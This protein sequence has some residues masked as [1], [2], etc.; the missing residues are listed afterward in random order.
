MQVADLDSSLRISK[1]PIL[2]DMVPCPLPRKIRAA[3]SCESA[4][5]R[6]R[7]R[8]RVGY[9]S[10]DQGSSY[11]STVK[12][13]MEGATIQW[14]SVEAEATSGVESDSESATHCQA[15]RPLSRDTASASPYATRRLSTVVTEA[16]GSLWRASMGGAFS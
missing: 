5:V 15:R 14:R 9:R 4:W 10:R 1:W 13:G 16:M 2:L 8:L 11:R 7:G 12:E 6:T 3:L